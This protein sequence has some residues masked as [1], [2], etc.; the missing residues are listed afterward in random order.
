MWNMVLALMVC[1]MLVWLGHGLQMPGMR[2]RNPLG[3]QQ[4]SPST[5]DKFPN[6]TAQQQLFREIRLHAAAIDK[7]I[8]EGD[9]EGEEE[10][11]TVNIELEVETEVYVCACI[12]TCYE[13]HMVAIAAALIL[14]LTVTLS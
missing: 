6:L 7:G 12:C 8:T 14:T 4:S 9:V 1:G 3:V 13:R 11:L 10:D 5:Q 2:L